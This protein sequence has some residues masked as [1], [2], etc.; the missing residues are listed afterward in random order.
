MVIGFF[1]K[2]LKDKKDE[3]I[4]DFVLDELEDDLDF[5]QIDVLVWD[6]FCVFFY[7]VIVNGYEDVVRLFC[8][9]SVFVLNWN[10][11]YFY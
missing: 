7:L 1:V 10:I 3:I 8:D 5:Y 2:I 11:V 6:V 4:D 9:V